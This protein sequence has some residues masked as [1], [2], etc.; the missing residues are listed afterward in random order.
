MATTIARTNK[1]VLLIDGDMRSP[2][3]H[4]L[5]E[6][7]H[8]RGLSNYLAGDDDTTTMTFLMP[9]LGFTAMSA[10]PIPPNAELLSARLKQLVNLML[11]QYDHVIVVVLRCLAW[12]MRH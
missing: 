2:S 7:S 9:D 5:G 10:G 4:H 12:P 11:E 6:V 8:D 3:V 1:K